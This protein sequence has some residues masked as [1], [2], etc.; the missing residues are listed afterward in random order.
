MV[1]RVILP[2]KEELMK[3]ISFVL[4]AILLVL[5]VPVFP[6][7]SGTT[8]TT[9]H[10]LRWS[11]APVMTIDKNKQYTATI[12]TNYGDIVVQLFPKDAPLTVNNFVFLGQQGFYNGVTFH[13]IMPGFVVQ[14]G[15]PTGTGSGGP[16]YQFADEIVNKPYSTGT[17]A[18][19][20]SGP[21]TNGSQFFICL[22][23]LSNQ[24]P[25]FQAKAYNIFGI[26]TSGMD[27]VQKI[28]AVPTNSSDAPTKDVHMN[29]V[30]INEQ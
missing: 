12:K 16:G 6:A 3:K 18:M 5:I 9:N 26:V 24:T 29:T 19:A 7:C 22:A 11:Q 30:V 23:D 8:L 1:T 25:D 14:G 20:N 10:N 4:I 28:A 2:T 27:V 17:L 13:R 15:D 21:N